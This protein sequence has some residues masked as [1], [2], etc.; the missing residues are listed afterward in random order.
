MTDGERQ[1]AAKWQRRWQAR[2]RDAGGREHAQR[3][4]RKVDAQRWLDEATTALVTGHYVDPR[5]GRVTI[6][7]Y[8]EQWRAIQV[9][10]PT[11]RAHVETMLRRHAY[12]VLGSR[13]LGTIL[14]SDVQAWVRRLETGGPGQKPLAPATIG[15]AHS[16]AAG[17]FKAAVRDRRIVASPCDGTRLP[18]AEAKHIVPPTTEQVAALAELMPEQLRAVVTFTA[19]GPG[20][21][22]ARC[23]A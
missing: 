8:A 22:R 16:I 13:Q 21:V 6:R 7:E 4:D 18:K 12:P 9:H 5:A 15:V 3:F 2:Y 10:R 1:E 20:C 11:S 23:S 19:G 17:V 14:P